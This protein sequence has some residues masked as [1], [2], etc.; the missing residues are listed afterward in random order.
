MSRPLPSLLT[1]MEQAPFCKYPLFHTLTIVRRAELCKALGVNTK[2]ITQW[3]KEGM[4]VIY[5][6]QE[7]S[8]KGAR[9]AYHLEKVVYWLEEYKGK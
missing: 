5:T 8:G 9:H 7:V 2:T 1:T 4:P 6:G 3:I